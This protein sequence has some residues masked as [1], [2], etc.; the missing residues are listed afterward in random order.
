MEHPGVAIF[1]EEACSLLEKAGQRTILSLPNAAHVT[2]DRAHCHHRTLA[3]W[4][5]T[6]AR[7]RPG[8]DAALQT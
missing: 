5:D 3:R 8:L 4:N 6:P 7:K 1:A 2:G